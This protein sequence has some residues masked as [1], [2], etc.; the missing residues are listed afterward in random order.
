MEESNKIIVR[1]NALK[2][3]LA[4]VRDG[5]G[6]GRSLLGLDLKTSPPSGNR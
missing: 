1:E 4:E 5:L 6:D 2:Q 3:L